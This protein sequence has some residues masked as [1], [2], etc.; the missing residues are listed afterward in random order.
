MTHADR[1]VTSSSRQTHGTGAL[2][3]GFDVSQTAEKRAGCGVF[4]AELFE[5]LVRVSA[6]RDDV[7]LVPLPVFSHYRHPDFRQA[8]HVAAPHVD[9]SLYQRS[10]A[11]LGEAW[12]A[13]GLQAPRLGQVDLVHS[14]SFGCPRDLGVPLVYTVYDMSP[15]DHP[16][17]HTEANR[18]VCFQGLFD[19]STRADAFIAISAFTRARFLHWFPHVAPEAVAV[20][21]PAAR[22]AFQSGQGSRDR[23]DVLARYGLDRSGFLLA[24]GTIEPRKNYGLMIDAYQDLLRRMPDAPP[25]CI[26]GQTGW[27]EGSLDERVRGTAAEARIRPLGFV[28]DHDLAVL[29]REAAAFLFASH[30]E[31]FGLPLVEALACGAIIV[32]A[33]TST[34][35]EV[36]GDAGLLVPAADP[37]AMAAAISRVLADPSSRERRE[38]AARARAAMFSWDEAARQTLGIHLRVAALPAT[39]ATPRRSL[40]IPDDSPHA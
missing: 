12:D 31:G 34:V 3:I 26:A 33:D 1:A 10:W 30:Y 38:T 14:N 36:V 13:P 6:G 8:V 25:L 28:P 20:V 23:D 18:L 17:F 2:R 39:G 35:A 7:T 4:Q 32:A 11:E 27:L 22:A 5:G 9:E 16:E 29:Y 40:P 21:H 24:V 15:L 19:A 37:A